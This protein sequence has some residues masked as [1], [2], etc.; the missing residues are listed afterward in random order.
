M[1]DPAPAAAQRVRGA[2]DH[3]VAHLLDERAG[4][5]G[6]RDRAAPR[7]RF[8]DRAHQGRETLSVL[9]RGNRLEFRAEQLDTMALQDSGVRELAAQVEGGLPAHPAQNP[10]RPLLG[11]HLL[12]ELN[13]ERLHVHGVRRIRVRLDRRRVAVH[14]DDPH[15]LLPKGSAR[16]GARVVELRGLSDHDRA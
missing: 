11:N 4:R 13:R 16:L 7:N 1:R 14:E 15:A 5:L 9:A 6:I 10:L 3:G 8:A 12:E 2:D